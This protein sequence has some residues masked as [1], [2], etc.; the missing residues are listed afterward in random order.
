MVKTLKLQHSLCAPAYNHGHEYIGVDI[1]KYIM[2]F[3]VVAIHVSTPGCIGIKLPDILV[4][5]VRL[6]VP[7][8]FVASG[9]FLQHKLER[10]ALEERIKALRRRSSQLI[11]LFCYWL[12]IYFP[13]SLY[14]AI[15]S[16]RSCLK[17]AASYVFN[18][19][20]N[21]ESSYAWPLWFI[22][23]LSIVC[24][25]WSFAQRSRLLKIVVSIL[26]VVTYLLDWFGPDNSILYYINMLTHRTMIGGIYVL[27][28]I[29]SYKLLSHSKIQF[30]GGVIFVILSYI[31]FLFKF[32]FWEIS[33]GL[34]VFLI[35]LGIPSCRKINFEY[36]RN[37][38]MWIYYVHMYPVFILAMIL[39]SYHLR[40]NLI[41]GYG[42]VILGTL[43][44]TNI[45]G[46][47]SKNSKFGNKLN[48]LI[49]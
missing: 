4:W 23:S 39:K 22:Y 45:L 28:G 43:I 3:A 11:K 32:P 15:D 24:L 27:A 17:S 46:Y 33:G 34:S 42:I 29:C 18:V 26:L 48:R 16:G 10:L 41:E 19:V 30:R 5:F 20:I 37:Q 38:S 7:F 12:I 9:F 25:I 35:S 44:I 8:F 40:L 47:L 21:G 31:L 14:L 13:I 6:A 1:C 36:L 49:K 2:A